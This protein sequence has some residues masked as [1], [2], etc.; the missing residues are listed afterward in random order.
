MSENSEPLIRPTMV[1]PAYRAGAAFAQLQ[2]D[3]R[4]GKYPPWKPPQLHLPPL[5]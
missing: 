4:A 1:L 2:K 3:T 5:G